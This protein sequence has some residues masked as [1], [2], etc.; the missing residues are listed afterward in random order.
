MDDLIKMNGYSYGVFEGDG[1][2]YLQTYDEISGCNR[3]VHVSIDAIYEWASMSIEE[4]QCVC[5]EDK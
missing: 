3:G 4:W 1:G 2:V 5:E